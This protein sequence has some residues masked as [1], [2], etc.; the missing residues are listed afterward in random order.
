MAC[1]KKEQYTISG[2]T[3]DTNLEGKYVY[4]I[5]YDNQNLPEKSDTVIIKDG[6]FSFEGIIDS[7]KVCYIVVDYGDVQKNRA[8]LLEE[9]SLSVSIDEDIVVNGTPLNDAYEQCLVQESG[10]QKQMQEA[11]EKLDQAKADGS[12]TDE[13]DKSLEA[14]YM[15]AYDQV[16]ALYAGYFEKNINNPLGKEL[17]TKLPWTRRLS[18]DQLTKVLSQ[19]DP[20]SQQTN[21]YIKLKE[22]L[23]A[24]K[25]SAV[26]NPFTDIVSKDPDGKQVALSDYAG[27]G[28]YV[29]I[30]F[31]ASWCPPCR[32]EMPNLVNIY[33]QFKDKNFEIVGYSLDKNE[34]AWKK[35]LQDLNMTWPQLSD[36]QYWDSK[37][38]MLYA[39]QSIP[40]TVLLNPEGVIIERN[41][42]GKE[43]LNKLQEL[44]K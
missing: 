10:Y 36:C 29:L 22:R 4:L 21:L 9:G 6:K 27:K 1:V 38:V 23:D 13:L 11:D 12:L 20:Q 18:E 31:W 14:E 7:V 5:Q 40:H 15:S 19:A 26:G 41:L 3:S 37:P 43:L 32:K 28:K 2:T 34:D 39:V 44:L 17:M 42:Q 33:Q 30:D 16:K 35:G 8:I 25:N 24:M